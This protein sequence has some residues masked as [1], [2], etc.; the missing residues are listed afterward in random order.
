MDALDARSYLTALRLLR[1]MPLTRKTGCH[2][3]MELFPSKFVLELRQEKGGM[4]SRFSL[5]VVRKTFVSAADS[6]E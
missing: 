1:P 6:T 5:C 4:N 3:A 2:I